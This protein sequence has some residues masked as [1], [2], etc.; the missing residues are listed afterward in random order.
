ML[1]SLLP[2]VILMSPKFF[3]QL[4]HFCWILSGA[5]RATSSRPRRSSTLNPHLARVD[6]VSKHCVPTEQVTSRQIQNTCIALN[7]WNNIRY[8]EFAPSMSFSTTCIHSL[9]IN[10]WGPPAII[11]SVLTRHRL[12]IR[13]LIQKNNANL[14]TK[15]HINITYQTFQNTHRTIYCLLATQHIWI[16]RI[17]SSVSPKVYLNITVHCTNAS[18]LYVHLTNIITRNYSKSTTI[19]KNKL[20][21]TYHLFCQTKVII[22]SYLWYDLV[23][24]LYMDMVCSTPGQLGELEHM[25][26]V[27]TQEM[28]SI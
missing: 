18:F 6:D 19:N 12:A 24:A 2:Q 9:R 14:H 25:L 3:S 28:T 7:Q 5:T 21:C 10:R 20:N 22:T 13:S 23:P 16:C 1:R 27:I 15:I 17:W 4:L 26:H 11:W 8:V